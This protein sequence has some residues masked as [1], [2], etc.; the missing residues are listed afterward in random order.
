MPPTEV[1]AFRD[2]RGNIP[3]QAWLEELEQS[4]PRA[5]EKCLGLILQLEEKGH[6]LRRPTSDALRDGIRELRAK[7]GRVNYRLLYFF[8]GKDLACC[9]HGI[10]KEG[11][12]PDAAIEFAINARRLVAQDAERYT[13]ELEL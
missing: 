11:A 7:V 13:G 12:V 10:T 3:L 9:S 2:H 4:E 1:R 6:E 8:F 5:Y